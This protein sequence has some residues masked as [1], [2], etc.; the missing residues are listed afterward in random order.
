LNITAL[1]F[2]VDG[3]LYP[4]AGI[5]RAMMT[6]LAGAACTNPAR[7]LRAIRVLR[8]Y[9]RAQEQLRG[10]PLNGPRLE[11][12]QI[13]VAAAWS[14]V[15]QSEVRVIAKHW[16][17][18]RPLDLL[19]AHVRPGA[20]GFLAKARQ[21]GYRLGVFSDYPARTKLLAMGLD[22]YFDAILC[23]QD[24][25]IQRFKPDPAGLLAT[26][27]RLY[28]SANEC[29]YIGDRPEVDAAAAK[30]AGMHCVILGQR[31]GG[32]ADYAM[33]R[34]FQALERWL[35]AHSLSNEGVSQ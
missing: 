17:E 13:R 34:D 5:R 10:Q 26:A 4:H 15:A 3:T 24:P 25:D 16:M 2:D 27:A 29:V 18:D 28:A 20:A 6:R 11:D 19:G 22:G 35:A 12:E 21:Q 9:R 14:G 1:I 8:A 33:L 32:P 7:G 23:A 31:K 30:H